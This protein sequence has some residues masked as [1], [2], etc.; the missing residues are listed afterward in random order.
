MY[1]VLQFSLHVICNHNGQ[2]NIIVSWWC[3]LGPPAMEIQAILSIQASPRE[4]THSCQ[5]GIRSGS[6]TW[7]HLRTSFF[8]GLVIYD[9][10]KLVFNSCIHICLQISAFTVHLHLTHQKILNLPLKQMNPIPKMT[11]VLWVGNHTYCGNTL[12]GL[13]QMHFL[14][15]AVSVSL[16]PCLVGLSSN[17]MKVGGTLI[18]Q[19]FLFL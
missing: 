2:L 7:K 5:I 11:I 8:S 14:F 3:R 17:R 10:I 18:F 12:K 9:S 1:F 16:C 4:G 6:L 13:S 19:N 15:F